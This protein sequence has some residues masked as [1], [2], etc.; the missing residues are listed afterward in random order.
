MKMEEESNNS[1]ESEWEIKLPDNPPDVEAEP[2]EE[3]PPAHE[4]EEQQVS[5]EEE[6]VR[7]NIFGVL[8]FPIKQRIDTINLLSNSFDQI[9]T[10]R[11]RTSP[12]WQ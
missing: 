11:N 5:S 1:E 7:S 4:E 8:F 3:E 6:E 10:H 2:E 9:T 12:W